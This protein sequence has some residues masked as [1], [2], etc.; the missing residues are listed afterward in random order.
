M[1]NI[2]KR[3][4]FRSNLSSTVIKKR[5]LKKQLDLIINNVPNNL[6]EIELIRYIYLSLGKILVFNTNYY[7]NSN[8]EIQ[9]QMF[10]K[11][12]NKSIPETNEIICNS[13]AELL[14]Y[15][16]KKFN[17]DA[18]TYYGI[19]APHAETIV[20]T[21]DNKMYSFNLVG[22]LSRIQTNRKTRHFAPSQKNSQFSKEFE[23]VC[24]R[25]FDSLSDEELKRI[26]DKLKYTFHGLYM[27]DFISMLKK[28]ISENSDY[29]IPPNV[30][31]KNEYDKK[32][33]MRK[34][35]VEFLLNRCNILNE[36]FSSVG[37]EETTH[38]YWNLFMETLPSEDIKKMNLYRCFFDKKISNNKMISIISLEYKDSYIYYSYNRILRK[39]YRNS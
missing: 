10:D 6:S 2:S 21:S 35:V 13:G 17:I 15:M 25:V 16:L 28:D 29:I 30:H 9:Y 31:F 18:K 23:F 37:F 1:L 27:N 14:T 36:Q 32:E 34:Y 8:S 33:N 20:H 38:Y 12:K 3:K 22:D 26:D 24:N 5:N 19:G 39:I 4:L 7:Y 11:F